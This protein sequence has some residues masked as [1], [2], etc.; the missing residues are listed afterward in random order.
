MTAVKKHNSGLGDIYRRCVVLARASVWSVRTA[1][2]SS[3]WLMTL[4]VCLTVLVSLFPSAQTFLVERMTSAVGQGYIETAVHWGLLTGVFVAGYLAIQ[5]VM[6]TMQRVIQIRIRTRCFE[7]VDATLASLGPDEIAD[8]NVSAKARQARQ[9]VDEGK[10]EQ[11]SIALLSTL[12]ALLVSVSLLVVIWRISPLASILVIVSL[13]P[14]TISMIVFS[15]F[16]AKRWPKLADA[17]RHAM[18]REEQLLYERPAK[19]LATYDAQARMSKWACIWRRRSCKLAVS[20]EAL[21]VG[22]DTIA[23]VVSSLLLMG[24]L[25]SLILSGANPSQLAGG[26]VGILSGI[27]ATNNVGY[28][29]GTMMSSSVA[30][31]SYVGFVSLRHGD[32]ERAGMEHAERSEGENEGEGESGRRG[33][34]MEPLPADSVNS[35]D[36][37]GLTVSYPRA[38]SAT[39]KGVDLHAEKGEM[40]ALV[41]ANGAGKTTTIQGIL[42]TLPVDA[43][44]VRIDG[45]D[46]GAEPFRLRHKYFGLLT[47]DY[48][49]YEL[50]VRDNLMIGSGGREVTDEQIND[51]LTR[52]CADEIVNRLPQ[53]LDTQLGDQWGGVGLSGGEWQRIAMARL[54]LRDAPIW[55][56]DEPTSNIDAETEAS[57]FHELREHAGDHITIVVS[58]RA[59]TLRAMDRIYVMD[60]G[61]IMESGTY[62]E[63]NRDGTRFSALFAFQNESAGEA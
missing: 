40:I 26:L 57:L 51:A 49:R 15:T 23:G 6:F 18:Y 21:S 52:A 4:T 3:P 27:I 44:Q 37:S 14:Q 28:M 63:L 62:D 8:T 25:A 32:E 7:Q 45:V 60:H 47:Q 17:N 61:R 11:L 41:G 59:W 20:L 10:V 33:A 58:H 31:E 22:F 50:T 5:Q 1:F 16:D 13:V 42:G 30:V 55:V 39:V 43:G 34:S 54:F 12:F 24:A 9:A 36:V 19:E 29:V 56:L 38:E 35:L 48:G 53:G 2:A 46:H